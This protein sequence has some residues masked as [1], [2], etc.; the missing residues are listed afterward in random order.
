MRYNCSDNDIFIVYRPAALTEVNETEGWSNVRCAAWPCMT[1]V[2]QGNTCLCKIVDLYGDINLGACVWCSQ[3]SVK[4]SILL[5]G[6]GN[7]EGTGKRKQNEDSKGK[8]KAREEDCDDVAGNGA[9]DPIAEV[10]EGKVS[11]DE[12]R[13][14]KRVKVQGELEDDEVRGS[15]EEVP[16]QAPRKAAPPSTVNDFVSTVQELIT[17]CR[18]GFAEVRDASEK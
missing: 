11:E 8:G 4:H 15:S 16:L 17:V 2:K 13:L 5:H 10:G 18:D 7:G 9:A 3:Q 6:K 1:C 14:A 12:E